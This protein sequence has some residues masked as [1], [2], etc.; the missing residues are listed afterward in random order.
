ML[1]LSAWLLACLGGLL[2]TSYSEKLLAIKLGMTA[3]LVVSIA[4]VLFSLQYSARSSMITAR[5]LALLVPAGV[6][7]IV[8]SWTN[9]FHGLVFL[10]TISGSG[11]EV[12][13][14]V[15]FWALV[16]Y[17]HLLILIGSALLIHSLARLPNLQKRQA[18]SLAV[19]A[20]SPGFAALLG[21]TL[22]DA[23]RLPALLAMSLLPSGV[24][25]ML[26][27][28][29]RRIS[30]IVHV[31]GSLMIEK[32][33]D[34]V[35]VIDPQDRIIDHNPSAA[36]LAGKA[37]SLAGRPITE[38]I[39]SL[40]G[41]NPLAGIRD[42]EEIRVETAEGATHFDVSISSLGARKG[43]RI[44]EL[45]VLRDVSHQKRVEEQLRSIRASLEESVKARTLELA[46][47][48]AALEA[49]VQER[50]RAEEQLRVYSRGLQELVEAKTRELKDAERLAGIGQTAAMVGHDL[51]NPLQAITNSIYLARKSLQDMDSHSLSA[52]RNSLVKALQTIDRE[53]AYMNKIVSDLQDFA[54]PMRLDRKSSDIPVLVQG[55]LLSVPIPENVKVHAESPPDFP[56]LS[57]DANM[58]KRVF[59]NLIT[60]AVQA[61]P[62]GG[63][64]HIS[65]QNLGRSISVRFRD[66]GVGIP[67]SNMDK[68]FQ[69]L[70]TTK[71]Q[72]Q[73]LGLPVCKR[74]VEAHGGRIVVESD[75]GK[76][77]TFQVELPVEPDE[78][79]GRTC[80]ETSEGTIPVES[81]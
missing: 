22:L 10:P 4:W 49:E 77:S 80:A 12:L 33:N 24:A 76:G 69:P 73:G 62:D 68:L 29:R 17:F 20:L 65:Y 16:A 58:V 47:T 27:Q 14:G 11:S 7:L 2:V 18:L 19:A 52:S 3:G 46:C 50:T 41:V 9:S 34:P 48:N 56:K 71:A 31:A 70:F 40:A 55:T 78:L 36:R 38:V 45:V 51:R 64:L 42:A 13:Y 72:G 32:M 66:T 43:Q 26:G 61:M 5:N 79:S 15:G 25:I 37:G 21:M 39:P 54:R 53:V 8:L 75:L 63:S 67:E 35:L 28:F 81:G 6:L 59:H 1:G 23:F 30:G 60:N 57:V 44:G 74:I